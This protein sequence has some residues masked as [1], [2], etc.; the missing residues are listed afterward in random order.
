MLE[1]RSREDVASRWLAVARG[2]VDRVAVSRWAEA[3]VFMRF[4]ALSDPLAMQALQYLDGFD[5]AYRSQ[6]HRLVGHGRPQVHVRSLDQGAQELSA[7][8]L[9]CVAYDADPA[10]WVR[11]RDARQSLRRAVNRTTRGE[12]TVHAEWHPLM[13]VERDAWLGTLGEQWWVGTRVE[14]H[15]RVDEGLPVALLPLLER[16]LQEVEA[17]LGE[18]SGLPSSI[19]PAAI[20]AF[21]LTASDYWAACALAWIRQ[22]VPGFDRWDLLE[23]LARSGT[24]TQSTRHAAWKLLKNRPPTPS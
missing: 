1:P 21:G 11:D 5:L 7:W 10:G 24:G 4:A 18:L 6:D 2:E 15:R 8:R 22:G 20:A 19:Q 12:G 3:L 9:R 16:P 13:V 17:Q 14:P 23:T